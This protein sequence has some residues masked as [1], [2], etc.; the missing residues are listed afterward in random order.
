MLSNKIFLWV[1]FNLFVIAMLAL[2]LGV[3]N[4][5]EHEIKIRESLIWTCVWI[6][7]A[8]L[9]NVGV[10]FVSGPKPAQEFLAGYLLEKSLSVDNLF[11]FILIF[12]YFRVAALHQHRVLFW[13]ILL[14]LI[15][16]AAF[17]IGGVALIERFHWVM[18]IFGAFLVITGIR[19]A[20]KSEEEDP[21]KNLILRLSRKIFHVTEVTDQSRFFIWRQGRL[22]MTPLF[23]VLMVINFA[24]VIFAT[25]SIP[26]ILGVTRNSFIVYSSNVFAILGLRALYF[27]IAGI[28]QLFYYLNYGL[29]AILVFIGAKMLIAKYYEIPIGTALGVIAG[30]ILICILA[31]LIH[32]RRIALAR[33]EAALPEKKG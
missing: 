18:Y 22:H 20:F 10:Y 13:G 30:I 21:E 32:E 17:I 19:M 7:L 33:S 26:A 5:K 28:M 12:N 3:F 9:F 29:S 4:R 31:S 14:A 1:A 11:V 15:L 24:D 8:L 2:D 16:R 27:A 25:D 6:T 23:L